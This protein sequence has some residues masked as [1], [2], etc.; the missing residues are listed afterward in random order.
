MKLGFFEDLKKYLINEEYEHLP[1]LIPYYETLLIHKNKLKEI[2]ADY[3]QYHMDLQYIENDEHD[4]Y[5]EG[6]IDIYF[7]HNNVSVDYHYEIE[8]S[9]RDEMQGYCQCTPEDEGYNEEHTC[10]G[11]GCDYYF[12]EVY[13]KKVTGIASA[14]FEG[15]ANELWELEK[16]WDKYLSDHHEEKKKVELERIEE[17]IRELEEKRANLLNQ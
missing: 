12:P 10:C 9:H 7:Y 13:I 8:L 2:L 14:Y 1:K 6:T 16:K 4:Y 11:Y 5:T 3:E 17:R 15:Y